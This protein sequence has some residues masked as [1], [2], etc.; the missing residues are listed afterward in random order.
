MGKGRHA[1][2]LAPVADGALQKG[3]RRNGEKFRVGQRRCDPRQADG[4]G[5]MAGLAVLLEET[6]SAIDHRL[7]RA[8]RVTG[9]ADYQHCPTEQCP[10][11]LSFG[12]HAALP[13]I[14]R[15]LSSSWNR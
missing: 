4:I 1:G 14:I 6:G 9:I 10:S 15:L 12:D 13:A 5:L 11:N 8:L 2:I 3:I 7:R